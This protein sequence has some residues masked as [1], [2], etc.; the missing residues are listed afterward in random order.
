MLREIPVVRKGAPVRILY[1]SGPMRI[2]TL[3]VSE[4]DGQ[5]GGTVR[6]RNTSSRKIL[7]ARVIG[8][9]TVQLVF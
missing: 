5:D 1:E 7:H 3:G 6:V 8:D 4:E 9:S 2:V